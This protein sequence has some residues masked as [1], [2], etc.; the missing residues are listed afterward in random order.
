[1]LQ[2]VSPGPLALRNP[3]SAPS[4]L[5][6]RRRRKVGETAKT[7]WRWEQFTDDVGSVTRMMATEIHRQGEYA[8]GEQAI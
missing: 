7:P 8:A 2:A 4:L 1:M 3:G 5:T 6:G